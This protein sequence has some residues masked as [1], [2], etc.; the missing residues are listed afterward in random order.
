MEQCLQD[1]YSPEGICF[2]CGPKNDEGLH[3]QSFVQA[4]EVVCDWQPQARHQAFP[5]IVNGGI[6]GALLDC[7]LNWTAAH[8]LMQ[9][10]GLPRSPCTVTADYHVKLRRPTPV[11]QPLHITARVVE[12]A[13][14]KAIVEG[15]MTS[16]GKLTATCRGTFVAVQPGHPAYHS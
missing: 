7:H 5:G 15:E 14:D 12:S 6:V 11:D 3:V 13:G 10:K 1:R 2:G 9:A 4:D 8:H 16:G